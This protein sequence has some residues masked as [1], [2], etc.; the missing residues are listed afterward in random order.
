MPRIRDWR[1]LVFYRPDPATRYQHIDTLFHETVNWEL[2]ETHWQDVMQVLISIQQGKISTDWLLRKLS[3]ESRRSRIYRVFREIGRVIRTI[4]LLQYLADLDLR[5]QITATTNKVEAFH[6]FSQWL[7]FGGDGVLL[8]SPDPEEQ[9]KAMLYQGM[10]ANAVID[11]NVVDINRILHDLRR[12]GMV[13]KRED[14]ATLSPYLT[15]HIKRFGD[16]Q[17]DGLNDMT[18]TEDDDV[19]PLELDE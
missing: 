4:F 19:P 12:E 2:I 5:I 9:E 14:V 3:S 6:Q 18:L 7:F 1:D 8:T 16:Y 17:I 13:V 15:Q 10:V 11:Q